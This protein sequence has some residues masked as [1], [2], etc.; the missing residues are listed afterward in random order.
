MS[1]EVTYVSNWSRSSQDSL[2]PSGTADDDESARRLAKVGP[3]PGVQE[4]A[5][6]CP[7]KCCEDF[8]DHR[9]N[10]HRSTLIDDYFVKHCPDKAASY[11]S[12]VWP[13]LTQYVIADKKSFVQNL[14]AANRS[15]NSMSK[16]PN[17]KGRRSGV[18]VLQ[19]LQMSSIL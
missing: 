5:V 15:G 12:I 6:L 7:A 2:N 16:K 1:Y 17:I 19:N 8:M 9:S 14:L 10:S 4:L 11:H 3:R 13:R 18:L